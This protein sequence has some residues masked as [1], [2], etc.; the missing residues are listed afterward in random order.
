MNTEPSP[1]LIH[2]DR[3][4]ILVTTICAVH[5]AT[6]P[7][8]MIAT[9]LLIPVILGLHKYLAFAVA[10]IAVIAAVQGWTKHRRYDIV[11]L[12]LFGATLISSAC[13]WLLPVLWEQG[14]SANETVLTC[15][16]GTILVLG[17]WMN[18]KFSHGST[19]AQP[20][21]QA[22]GQ[23]RRSVRTSWRVIFLVTIS[24]ALSVLLPL[25]APTSVLLPLRALT[26][27]AYQRVSFRTLRLYLPGNPPPT[28]VRNLNNQKVEIMGFMAALNQLE[29]IDE[30]VLSSAPPM[31]CFCHPPGQVNELILVEMKKG[32]TLPNYKS[33]VVRVRGTLIINLNIKPNNQYSEVM[34]TIVADEAL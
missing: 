2:L 21:A 34:Y 5:C 10:P 18:N 32:S 13:T 12:L 22:Q 8:L 19:D 25:R 17:H 7:F 26:M 23:S 30:F 6:M 4:G 9:P 1:K 33:G 29:D 28:D 15:V 20:R 27:E 16:G 3:T 14:I 31:N 11:A 24:V